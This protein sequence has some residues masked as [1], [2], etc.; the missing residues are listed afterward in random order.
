M[1]DRL[2]ALH[3]ASGKV[4][5]IYSFG[6]E[7]LLVASDRISAFDA[8]MPTPIPDKGRILTALST[9]WFE[10]TSALAPNH[11]ITIEQKAFPEVARNDRALA[12]R[13]MLVRRLTMMP[14]ECVVRGYLA[15]SGWKDYQ[16]TGSICGHRLRDGLRESERLPEPI[17]TPA[18]KSTSGHDINIDRDTAVL[19]VGDERR[20]EQLEQMSL[21]VYEHAANYARERGIII[22][23]TK[24]EFGLD[25]T[26]RLVLGDELL[27]PDSSRFWP[28]DGYEPGR[29][30]PSFDKQFLRDWLERQSWDKQP[31]GPELPDDVVVGTRERYADAYMRLTGEPISAYLRR[32]GAT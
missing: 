29:P 9:F 6:E 2:A 10:R 13:A 28:A 30:Q 20:Y 23:D 17:F 32:Q 8:I 25:I 19:L 11:M 26:G 1:S 3:E 12:G 24:M 4:R 27:T 5:E 15:G 14:I 18:T 16:A 31:P 21:N 7:L 22:A